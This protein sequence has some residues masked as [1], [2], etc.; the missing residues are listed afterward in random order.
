M[1]TRTSRTVLCGLILAALVLV[2]AAVVTASP[3]L[4]MDAYQP[5]YENEDMTYALTKYGVMAG[6]GALAG[7]ML[8][9]LMGRR[10]FDA[11][12]LLGA[13]ASA[14]AGAL[15]GARLLY[16]LVYAGYIMG[17][18]VPLLSFCFQPW[19]GG[20]TLYGGL[21][22]GIAGTALYCRTAKL[23]LGRM[24]DLGAPAGMIG[25]MLIRLGE[26]FTS[27]G[28]GK[29]IE[30]VGIPFLPFQLTNEYGETCLVVWKYEVL[31]AL[32]CALAA[33]WMLKKRGPAGRSAENTL[34]LVSLFQVICESLRTDEFVRFGFVRLNMIAAGIVLL[35]I[36]LSRVVRVHRASGRTPWSILR[37][38]LLFLGA[39]IVIGI[40]FALEKTPIHNG[41]LY[42]GMALMLVMMG[43]CVLIGDGRKNKAR[44]R[45]D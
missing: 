19:Q 8:M 4:M 20:Y 34:A 13:S 41:I 29:N 35:V 18:D 26:A 24:M 31:A 36:L 6:V 42:A 15:L 25:L 28:M 2:T 11:G 7:A 16:V 17:C 40:E 37:T 3:M 44:P 39:G 38:V 5:L 30:D 9:L 14:I 21:L 32:V 10:D 27:Q 22:G 1:M 12:H 23:P 45:C 33:L 43:C